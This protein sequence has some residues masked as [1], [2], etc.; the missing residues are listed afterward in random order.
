MTAIFANTQQALHVSFLVMSQ[1]VREKN[2][3]RLALIQIIESIGILNRRQAAFLQYLYGEKSGSVNFD[4]LSPLEVRGQCAMITAC[5]LH[6]LPLAERHAIWIRFGRGVERKTGVIWMA[7]KL[8]ASL[9]VT[10]LDAIRYLVAEQSLPR[11]ERD[12]EKTFKYIAERTD[13]PVRTLERAAMTIRKQL[14]AYENS[15]YDTLTPLFERDELIE[16]SA[17]E[18]VQT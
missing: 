9:N 13:V 5:V 3:L 16:W 12:P 1:P 2:G 11:D 15:A 4:G 14:R 8:R 10:N 6:Q 17:R 7:K 18:E